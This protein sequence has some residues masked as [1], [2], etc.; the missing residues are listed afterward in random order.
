MQDSYVAPGANKDRRFA[1]GEKKLKIHTAIVEA[2]I[3][4]SNQVNVF[5][6]SIFFLE[7]KEKKKLS[8]CHTTKVCKLDS[9]VKYF[10]ELHPGSGGESDR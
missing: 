9:I 10:E 5:K 6:G 8:F 3:T 7:P 4:N 2:F 1:E